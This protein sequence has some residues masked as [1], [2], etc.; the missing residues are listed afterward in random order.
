MGESATFIK[1]DSEKRLALLLEK[2]KR[3]GGG[4]S[5]HGLTVHSKNDMRG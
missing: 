1:N 4:Q 3:G 5:H 2:E